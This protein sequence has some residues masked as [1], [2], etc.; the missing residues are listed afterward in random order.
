MRQFDRRGAPTRHAPHYAQKDGAALGLE[1]GIDVSVQQGDSV[2]DVVEVPAA[3]VEEMVFD[4]AEPEEDVKTL[5]EYL[6]SKQL[7]EDDKL[8]AREVIIDESQFNKVRPMKS[9]KKTD[10]E[11]EEAEQERQRQK[12]KKE[13][14]VLNLDEFRG[15]R[16]ADSKYRAPVEFAGRGGFRG[17]RGGPRG[18]A[19]PFTGAPRGGRG[20]FRGV[21]AEGAA[22]RGG[23][24]GFAPRGGRGG[25]GGF[26]AAAPV[27]I[28]DKAAFPALGGQ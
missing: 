15:G 26:G 19:T 13:R 21:G 14:K 11:E 4:I 1:G 2:E 3:D 18:G 6:A 7:V 23:R 22:H 10:E 8:E 25:R 9:S 17:G 28:N 16:E 12:K 20:G 5:D 24:G 27:A